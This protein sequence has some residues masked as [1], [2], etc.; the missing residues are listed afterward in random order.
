MVCTTRKRAV[1]NTDIER[2]EQPNEPEEPD[3]PEAKDSVLSKDDSSHGGNEI[4]INLK[5]HIYLEDYEISLH[6][7]LG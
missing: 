7:N 6:Q 4:F 5:S 2:S 3:V 1:K